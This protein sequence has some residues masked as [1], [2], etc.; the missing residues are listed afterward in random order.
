MVVR[1]LENIRH[2]RYVFTY[3]GSPLYV[4]AGYISV[5][6]KVLEN[7]LVNLDVI[8]GKAQ[9]D[10]Q[11]K[12]REQGQ[13]A[14]NDAGQFTK[15]IPYLSQDRIYECGADAP[16]STVI[17]YKMPPRT[18]HRSSRSKSRVHWA[19]PC[20]LGAKLSGPWVVE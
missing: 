8:P 9:I 3:I 19:R 13:N 5:N 11:K 14:V 15:Y 16:S 6:M 10:L 1:L 18:S 17:K 7:Q 4:T 2:H 20:S 12:L